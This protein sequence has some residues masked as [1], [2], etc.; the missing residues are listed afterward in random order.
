MPDRALKVLT[1]WQPLASLIIEGAKPFEFRGWR[2]PAS[3][4]GQRI[5]IH[6]A[7]R[8]ESAHD[9]AGLLYQLTKGGQAAAMT[10]LRPDIAIPILQRAQG[11]PLSCGLGTAVLGEPRNGFDIAR[12]V[13]VEYAND[14]DRDGQ[15]N[16]GWPMLNI[17]RWAEPVPARGRQG[18]WNWPTAEDAGL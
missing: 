18:L 1:I 8:K 15:A 13:G 14:S 11:R 9:I 12:E 7:A 17:E 5:V 10:C 4:V 16:W 3:L 2:A 6:A